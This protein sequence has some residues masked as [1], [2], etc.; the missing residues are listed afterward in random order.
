MQQE[1]TSQQAEPL[2]M[3]RKAEQD[4]LRLLRERDLQAGSTIVEKKNPNPALQHETV[5]VKT[6]IYQINITSTTIIHQYHVQITGHYRKQDGS[7]TNIQLAG[8][9]YSDDYVKS[10]RR[11][12]CRTI[13]NAASEQ[14]P[15]VFSTLCAYYDLASLLYTIQPLKLPPNGVITIDGGSLANLGFHFIRVILKYA[16][17][18]NIG[19]LKHITGALSEENK[20][21]EQFLNIATSQDVFYDG[22]NF[23]TFSSSLAYMYDPS[24]VGFDPDDLA[25]FSS[26]N[27]FLGIGFGKSVRIIEGNKQ[28]PTGVQDCNASTAF[29]LEPKKTPFHTSEPLIN[30]VRTLLKLAPNSDF[31]PITTDQTDHLTASLKGLYV[32]TSHRNAYFPIHSISP[33]NSLE[34][35]ITRHGEQEQISLNDYYQM[36]HGITLKFV[37]APL[38][39]VQQNFRGHRQSNFYPLE[40]LTVCED[41]RVKGSQGNRQTIQEMIKVCAVPPDILQAQIGLTKDSLK[42]DDDNAFLKS[43]DINVSNEPL[44]VKANIINP[45]TLAFDQEEVSVDLQKSNIWIGGKFLLGSSIDRWGVYALNRGSDVINKDELT[46]FARRYVSEC[47]KRGMSVTQPNDIDVF[48]LEHDITKKLKDLLLLLKSYGCQFALFVH[49][50]KGDQV[51]HMIKLMEQQTGVVTQ[52]MKTQ[53]VHN[54]MLG[55]ASETLQNI[56]QKT[57]VKIGGL[58]YT[59]SVSSPGAEMLL[60]DTLFIGFGIN[61]PAGGFGMSDFDETP[62]QPQAKHMGGNGNVGNGNNIGGNGNAISRASHSTGT[63]NGINGVNGLKVPTVIGFAANITP[64]DPFAFCGGYDYQ[65]VRRD[66]QVKNVA[67]IVAYCVQQYKKYRKHFPSKIVIYRNGCGEG[68]FPFVLSYEIPMIKYELKKMGSEA[69]LTFIVPNKLQSIRFFHK[70]TPEKPLDPGTVMHHTITHP[71]ITEFHL[72]SH[73]PVHGTARIPVYSVLLDENGYSLEDLENMTYELCYGHQI[74]YLPTSVPTPVYV[75]EEYAKRGRNM[76]NKWVIENGN[77]TALANVKQ[78]ADITK[79]LGHQFVECLS[80]RRVNA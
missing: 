69:P 62:V 53:T 39:Q 49:P 46:K 77:G 28:H 50:D 41:Q 1:Q 56:I 17:T 64:S 25:V 40:L 4:S 54:I 72:S 80:N 68:K 22:P 36:K 63:G 48:D 57:N 15:E 10:K 73:H 9:P 3:R 12:D 47:N 13:L 21:L 24:R 59:L 43:I 32:M 42:L 23:L 75:A 67:D 26:N 20:F 79:A 8:V 70:T 44:E 51:H 52:G 33:S 37:K 7:E 55:G 30:K 74:V 19:D 61:H 27:S 71:C 34:H 6:N 5:D 60:G 65:E 31:G 58:N 18:L 16:K 29:V 38:V 2:T 78:Y 66:I 76:Y 11:V 14:N 35:K 45:P